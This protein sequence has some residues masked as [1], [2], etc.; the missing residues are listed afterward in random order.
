MIGRRAAAGL[1]LLSALLFSA[2]AAQGASAKGT[3]AFT[4]SEKAAIIDFADPNCTRE[5]GPPE[6]KF[7][8]I[9]IAQGAQTEVEITNGSTKNE[10][11]EPTPRRLN[12]RSRRRKVEIVCK[13]VAGTAIST[14][15]ALAGVM[16][17]EGTKLAIAYT[18]CVV[19]LPPNAKSKN[20]S[21]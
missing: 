18:E 12:R 2:F 20:R 9:G 4:C 10:T 5:I 11:K 8:H 3:T 17:N 6:G 15:V 19:V 21:K 14:N 7:G 13:K 1:A 16:Q